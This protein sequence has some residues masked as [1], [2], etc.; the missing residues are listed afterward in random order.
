LYLGASQEIG[1]ELERLQT[2]LFVLN[3]SSSSSSQTV[4]KWPKHFIS[5]QCLMWDLI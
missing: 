3:V 1:W 5:D 2:D 4:L